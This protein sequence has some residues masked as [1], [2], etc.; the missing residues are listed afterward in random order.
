V[1]ARTLMLLT[2]LVWGL[3]LGAAESALGRDSQGIPQS[4]DELLDIYGIA[5]EP[6][7]FVVVVDTSSSM[8]YPPAIYPDVRTAYVAFTEA[9]GDQDHLAVVTFD[10]NSTVRFNGQ[11]GPNRA[12]AQ[13]ALPEV[14]NGANTDIGAA[15]AAA[16]E[17][18]ERPDGAAVQTLI[19][20]TDGKID[21]PGSPFATVGSPAWKELADRAA[22]LSLTRSVAVYGAGLGSGSTD[23][24]A[25]KDV[26][27]RA[28]I[29]NLPVNQLADFFSEAVRRARV[30]K[31]RVPVTREL[32]RNVVQAKLE[33]EELEDY[34]TL[35]LRFESKLPNLGVTVS[36]RGVTVSDTDGEPLRAR[37][38]GGATTFTLGPR[39]ISEPL[40]VIVE[41]PH[42]SHELRV[43]SVP[44]SR[45]LDVDVDAVLEAEPV[46]VLAQD[47]ALETRP[48]LVQADPTTAHRTHG[49]PYWMVGVAAVVLLLIA[50]FLVW[51]Y[52]RLVAVPKLRGGVEWIEGTEY[53]QEYFRGRREEV[54]NKRIS[55][56]G[57]GSS[58]V[59][60]TKPRSFSRPLSVRNP[61]LWVRLEDGN[62]VIVTSYG[63]DQPLVAP[64]LVGP[65]DR[66]QLGPTHLTIISD[67]SRRRSQ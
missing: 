43:G 50:N 40:E 37:L 32:E 39:Q 25:L 31:L 5:D 53:H 62:N 34:T 17:R 49:I 59:F 63:A 16:L 66:I 51:L 11:V 26:F 7:D 27:P 48:V 2:V 1:N 14:A 8:S 57:G 42:L 9:V 60:F 41:V 45:T 58:V 56:N 6:S 65:T 47:L 44:D 12:A 36:I 23:I 35:R 29:V 15:I 61:R 54:P 19:F 55:F 52:R 20:L 13:S 33:A 64:M 22:N 24:S 30:E 18:L 21:A 46:S 38:V 67:A 3:V 28:Q 4:T 10:T